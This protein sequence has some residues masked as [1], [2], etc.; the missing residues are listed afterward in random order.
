MC[1]DAMEFIAPEDWPLVLGRFRTALH[2][3]GWLY[4]TVELADPDAVREANAALR[5]TGAPAVDGE[6]MWEE[7]DGY[8]HHY[9]ALERVRGWLGD[10]GFA[11]ADESEGPWHDGQYAYHHVLARAA[12][13]ASVARSG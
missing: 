12:A 1:V 5:A 9:P 13:P 10:A 4:L 8:Y 7:P 6:V 3:G 11:I 2:P